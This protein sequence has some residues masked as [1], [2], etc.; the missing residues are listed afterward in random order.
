[1]RYSKRTSRKRFAIRSDWKSLRR[2]HV[3]EV[4][5]NV[6]VVV[7]F[8]GCGYGGRLGFDMAETSG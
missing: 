5:K 6:L 3:E 4:T 2:S 8:V 7:E 1:V